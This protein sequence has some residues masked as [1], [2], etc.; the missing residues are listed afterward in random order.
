MMNS[1]LAY[2]LSIILQKLI[3]EIKKIIKNFILKKAQD[4]IKR[5]L[6]KKVF[7]SDEQIQKAEK[8]KKSAEAMKSLMDIFQYES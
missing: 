6:A 4:A 7:I 3:K 5:K 8:A 2:L 1:M